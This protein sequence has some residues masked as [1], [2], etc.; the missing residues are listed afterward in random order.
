MIVV[1]LPS[2]G[3]DPK[4]IEPNSLVWDLFISF[5]TLLCC[6]CKTLTSDL[7]SM[8]CNLTPD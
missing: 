1:C 6:Y 5:F 8:T 7:G 2:W 4:S 3:S